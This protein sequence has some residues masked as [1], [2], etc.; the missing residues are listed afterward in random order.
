[1]G[2]LVSEVQ[3]DI[4]YQGLEDYQGIGEAK[5]HTKVFKLPKGHIESSFPSPFQILA[6]W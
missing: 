6:R 1:M 3:K 4:V 5:G 2:T